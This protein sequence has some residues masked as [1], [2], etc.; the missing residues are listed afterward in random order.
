M[1]KKKSD[2]NWKSFSLRIV[3]PTVL[4][5]ALFIISIFVVI[6]PN[7]EMGLM[8]Q[9][10]EMIRELT[11]SAWSILA[12]FDQENKQ[13]S[14]GL[15][16]AQQAAIERIKNL[17][18]GE[19][20]KD[21]FWITDMYPRMIMHP[22]RP[23][24]NGEDLTTYR[25]PKGKKLFVE[26]VNKVKE[27]GS[28]YI[29]YMWQWKDDSLKIVPKLSYV[30]GFEPWG[31]IIGTGIY[32]EDVKE[33]ISAMTGHMVRI[34][35]LISFI[36]ILILTYLI[37][38]SLQIEKKRRKAS[39][40]SVEAKEKYK[41]LV[42]ASTEG[43]IMILEGDFIY[44]NQS[45]LELLAYSEEEFLNL[46]IFDIFHGD[47]D[48]NG[49]EKFKELIK[50]DENSMQFETQ[51]RKKDGHAADVLMT[52]SKISYLGKKGYIIVA[53]DIGRDKK[54]RDEMD[55]NKQKL[56]SLT[57]NLNIGIFRTT[58]GRHGK[59][60]E[61]N[62]AA[63]NILGFHDREEL[64]KIN[65]L[66]LFYDNERRKA[67]LSDLFKDGNVKNRIIQLNAE[68]GSISTIAVSAVI[69]I[70]TESSE[71]YCD[72]I[73][74]DITEQKKH[75]AEREHLIVELQTSLL[76]MNQPIKHILRPPVICNMA[77]P[78][79]R[80]A[81]MMS[82]KKY[83][84]ALIITD[85]GEFVGIITDR[86][87]RERVVA[88]EFDISKP[89]F[90]VMSSPLV[91]ISDRA[92]IFEATLL[93]QEKRL[94]HLAVR[95]DEG[96]IISVISN[97]ELMQVQRHSSNFLVREIKN[98][99][100]V[101]DVIESHAAV[102]GIVK[103]LIDSGAKT[104]NI[105]RI[106][107]G[108]SDAITTKL[109][110]FA[111]NELG[112]PP[113]AFAFIA[114]GSE[115]RE[116]QTLLTDQD[117][118]I[119]Y[120]DVEENADEV[121]SYFLELGKKVCTWL[122]KAGYNFCSGDIMA[123]NPKWCQP[124]SVWKKYFSDWINTVSPQDLLDAAIFYDFRCVYGDKNLTSELRSDINNLIKN[125]NLFLFHMAQNAI[126]WKA[127]LGFFGNIIVESSD[128]Q[129]GSFNIKSALM[130]IQSFARIYALKNGVEIS[131]TIERLEFLHKMNII[132]SATFEK[133]LDAYNFLM[134]MRF[135]HQ[136]IAISKNKT[137]DNYINLKDL[138]DIEQTT[139]KKIFSQI[140]TFQSKLKFDFT[141]TM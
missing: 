20:A 95:N 56:K 87:L 101:D 69:N 33:K 44:V 102:P 67:F 14:M 105:T 78:V 49:L 124:L 38:Q 127:P 48:K 53:R 75:E 86:D 72:G 40:E 113:V 58:L 97:D 79:R 8:D 26:S 99:E 57:N 46:K 88:G 68:D 84:A 77:L 41:A 138:S 81:E 110:H 31:W 64:F 7:F 13:D 98:A 28:G 16:E 117:N 93:M 89:A 109:I 2:I 62:D 112:E 73:I 132:P 128:E 96:K 121:N 4:A 55:I 27:Q 45:I 17:R 116:E 39:D 29:D 35:L 122:D 11:N 115:G 107:S 9:K 47:G 1:N 100:V 83:S 134:L 137:P 51:L 15:H 90:K 141:G 118:A 103:A 37:R 42:E 19:E 52:I 92:L 85:N 108:I 114:L 80:V 12:E 135:K 63:V 74:E 126:Q 106:I 82:R 91:T 111:V 21:Y 50:G 59:F 70:D 3:L 123:Q 34:S 133:I 104:K 22:Y 10:K 5:I 76:F 125:K 139:L 120:K 65:I 23:E 36:I 30:K 24:M 94:R 130:P 136:A 131:N 60:I 43:T 32:L 6:I 129:S 66:D 140:S 18:Y 54:F 119:I 61:A 25:D 71:K